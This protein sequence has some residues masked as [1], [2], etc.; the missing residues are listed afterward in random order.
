MVA[1]QAQAWEDLR[2]EVD[3]GR[4]VINGKAVK[5]EIIDFN[6]G[7]NKG[8]TVLAT[9]PIIGEAVSGTKYANTLVNDKSMDRL[10]NATNK[11]LKIQNDKLNEK[12]NRV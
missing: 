9:N 2:Q 11:R 10:H 8:A 7:V 6:L 5:A 3:A 1:I 12:N 4:I